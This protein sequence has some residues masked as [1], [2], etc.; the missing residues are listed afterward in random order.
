MKATL[1]NLFQLC[2]LL[3]ALALHGAGAARLQPRSVSVKQNPAPLSSA[4]TRRAVSTV[5]PFA[6]RQVELLD[7][8][9]RAAMERNAKYLLELDADRLLH[10]ARKYAGL[11]PKG[12]LYGGWEARGVAGHS[13]GH[14]LTRHRPLNG[15]RLLS[16]QD[17]RFTIVE[18]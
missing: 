9:F 1:R 5:E 17:S 8:P 14:Y 13:L 12:E 2:A 15:S 3:S 4:P 11:T 10:N 18:S 6:L 16:I 7:S